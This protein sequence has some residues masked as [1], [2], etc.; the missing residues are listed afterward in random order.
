VLLAYIS[1]DD[2]K[3]TVP[4]L[5]S[6]AHTATALILAS[7][8]GEK[9]ILNRASLDDEVILLLH[10]LQSMGL[11]TEIKDGNIEVDSRDMGMSADLMDVGN[12]LTVFSLITALASNIPRRTT[13]S[14]SLNRDSHLHHFVNALLNLGIVCEFPRQDWSL[15]M[16][17]RGPHKSHMTHITGATPPIYILALTLGSLFG[18]RPTRIEV[19]PPVR[20]PIL[21]PN[22]IDLMLSFGIRAEVGGSYVK[23]PGGQRCQS[24]SVTIP[25]DDM[26]N[27]FL[28]GL[29]LMHGETRISSVIQPPSIC[30][31]LKFPNVDISIESNEIVARRCKIEISKI[32]IGSNPDLLPLMIT[33]ATRFSGTTRIETDERF[34]LPED[35]KN[36][37]RTISFLNKM[38]CDILENGNTFFVPET[39]LNPCRLRADNHIIAL[40]QLLAASSTLG[41]SISNIDVLFSRYPGIT[42]EL[43]SLGLTLD[44]EKDDEQVFLLKAD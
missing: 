1:R 44:L 7:M 9:S 17:V 20:K 37:R 35:Y 12:S 8:T 14:G 24:A 40:A 25:T 33:L 6:P 28:I 41:S 29:G 10:A 3:G 38:G 13:I 23:L 11:K 32:E 21:H 43:Q 26:L 16:N 4:S 31:Y 34:M 42:S 2:I 39:V 22:D 18:V 36:L 19:S 15:P 5:P 30:Q 27:S